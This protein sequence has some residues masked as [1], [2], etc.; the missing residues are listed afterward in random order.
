MFG[1]RRV[2]AAVLLLDCWTYFWH[3]LNHAVPLFW[4]FHR[5]HHSEM[6]MDV[7]SASRF[8]IGEIIFSSLLRLPLII[9]LG[10]RLKELVIYETLMFAVVQFHHAN[11]NIPRFLENILRWIIVTPNLH[12]VHHS[13]WMPETNSNFS[14]FLSIWDTL[15]DTRRWRDNAREIHFGL[16]GFDHPQHHTLTGLLQTPLPKTPE[17]PE[18]AKG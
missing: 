6:K 7:T 3:R 16:E 10:V 9:L 1:W 8:H 12:R 18:Q 17:T 14:S 15:F 4:Q 11:I 2:V 5:T 13:R